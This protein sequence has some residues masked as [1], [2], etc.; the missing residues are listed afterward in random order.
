MIVSDS[1]SVKVVAKRGVLCFFG[2]LKFG[3]TEFCIK[4]MFHVWKK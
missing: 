4:F 2:H 3:I 1:Y